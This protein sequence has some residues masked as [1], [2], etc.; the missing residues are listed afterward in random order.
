VVNLPVAKN[1]YSHGVTQ[2]QIESLAETLRQAVQQELIAGCSFLVAHKGETVFRKAFGYADIESKRLFTTE[3]LLPIASVSKPFMASVLMVL[4]EQG[5]VKLED[6]VEKYLPEF[7]GVRVEGSQSPARPMTVRHLLSHTAGFWGN[8][9]ITPEKMDLIRNFERPLAEAVELIA[10][11]DLLYEPGTKFT[12]SGTGYCVA[13]RVAEVALGQSLEEIA[14]DALFR[15]LGLNRTTYLPSKE[16]R[17]T[18]PT[19][20]LRQRGKLQKQPSMAEID[21][22]FILPGGSLFTTLDELAVFGQMHLND[23]VYNGKRILSEASVT[24]MRRLQ[25]PEE[26]RRSYGLG[27]FR[28]DVSESGLADLVFHNGALGAHLRIDRRREVV[29]VFLV[30]QTAGPFLD[31]KNKRYQQVNEM[32]L[33]PKNE[34]LH[35]VLLADE[36]DHGPAGNGLHD[37]PLWQKRWALLLGGEEASEERQV[38]LVGP[39]DKNTDYCKGMP[40][41]QVATA[42]H[43]PSEE[44]FQTADVIVAYCYLEWTDERLAQVRRYLE[45]G[46]GLVLIHSA[47]WTKPK[48]S[49]EVAEVVGVG[50]FEL[51]RHGAVRLD[52]V[53]PEHPICAGLPETIIL[54][55]DE[56]YW[57]PT[58][59]M[60]GVTVLATSVED[61][62]KRGSTPKA[63]QPMFWCYELGEGR[64]FGC[65]PGHRAHTFD[66]PVI[67]KLLLRGMIWAAGEQ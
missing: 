43:W 20:Y 24:E 4:V 37:Y 26:R 1:L 25:S 47:T 67:R 54:K 33:V 52:M 62:A 38:N 16:V 44:H 36:K 2:D 14:Q 28:G 60:E 3:E 13:G 29:T 30:H 50:G 31:L 17:K 41:V 5:K 35:V 39:P 8:K 65:V 57:P 27:W 51:F 45:D 58:P 21:L 48:P 40:N 61:K 18:V 23:G 9:G 63:A 66:D 12:Y 64:V 15:P 42:W 56:T 53:A 46:G 10:E 32:F 6:P 34:K 19:A 11:Y 7:K 49:R 22:R 59:I 55:D